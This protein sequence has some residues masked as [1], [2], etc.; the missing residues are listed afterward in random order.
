MTYGNG[1]ALSLIVPLCLG[2]ALASID[3]ASI[4]PVAAQTPPA[5]SHVVTL[6]T[7]GGPLPR[8]DRA[9]PSNLLSV[10]GTLYLIDAGDGVTQR[11]VQ[12]GYDFG[13]IRKVFITHAHGDHMSGLAPLLLARWEFQ[14]RDPVDV[15][16]SGAVELVKGTIAYLTPNADIRSV[17]GK[18]TP[19]GQTFH[20]HDV[21]PGVVYQDDK[22]KVT[23]VENT[24]FHFPPG[25]R[26][27]GKY[28]SY[29][30]RFETPDRVIVFAG[31]TGPSDALTDLAKGADV[32]VTEVT[33]VSDVI[34]IFKRDGLWQARTAEEQ[35]GFVHMMEGEHITPGGV[36]RL[37]AKAGVRHVVMTHLG[38]TTDPEDDYRRYI[39]G[40]REFYA[41]PVTIAK[42]LM[43]F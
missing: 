38:P 31:D 11:I 17:Q 5:G 20:G 12:A 26:P 28:A 29:S 43:E 30:Y 23:A 9:Q 10:G 4:H 19:L 15:Y 13:Q 35:D 3:F 2:I 21:A 39:D 14:P 33:M 27:D 34:D 36:G 42:D 8:K 25:S 22:V 37:A 7:A 24:H 18:R 32:L 40:A 41:G 1:V 6:G 16:G